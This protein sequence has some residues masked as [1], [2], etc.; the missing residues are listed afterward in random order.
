MPR[1]AF[2]GDDTELLPDGYAKH[3][4]TGKEF[5]EAKPTKL[6]VRE[7]YREVDGNVYEVKN[8]NPGEFIGTLNDI[9][10]VYRLSD[11]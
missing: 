9:A 7:R 10:D 11:K 8:G 4:K 6:I 2:C 5:C 3:V 1:C